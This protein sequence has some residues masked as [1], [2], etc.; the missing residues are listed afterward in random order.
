M[1]PWEGEKEGERER[2]K[3]EFIKDRQAEIDTVRQSQRVSP[4]DS[5]SE[6]QAERVSE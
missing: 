1:D 3:N 4:R 5:Q 2:G 6:S